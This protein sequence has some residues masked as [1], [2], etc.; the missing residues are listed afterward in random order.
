MYSLCPLL[1]GLFASWR[2]R[3]GKKTGGCK[4]LI[5]KALV[6]FLSSLDFSEQAGDGAEFH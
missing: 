4:T 5:N 1:L 2:V 6:D 3:G